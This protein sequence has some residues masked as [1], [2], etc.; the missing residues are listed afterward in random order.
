[1]SCSNSKVSTAPRGS[2]DQVAITGFGKWSKDDPDDV[3]R[4]ATASISV[5]P[6]APF[7]AIIVFARFPGENQTLP[8]ALVL[9]NDNIDVN[10]STA[11][12]KPATKPVP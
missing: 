1:M 9:T 4:F 5:D 11:E 3:P 2:Y 10:L 7:A 6:N 8:G 12:N